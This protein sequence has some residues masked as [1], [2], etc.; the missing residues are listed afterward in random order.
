MKYRPEID[1]LRAFAVVPV[2]LFHAGFNLFSGGFVGVDIFF[3]ISGYL[4]TTIIIEDLE[5]NTF[6][7][8]HFYERRTRRILPALFFVIFACIPFAW[9]WM[10]PVQMEDFSKSIIFVI[11][12]SSNILFAQEID[13]FDRDAEENPLLHTWSLAVEEQYYFIFPIALLLCWRFGKSKVFW[14]I[15][16]LAGVSLALSEAGWR[17]NANANFYFTPSRAWELF[18]GSVAA[19]I[20]QKRGIKSN[21]VFSLAG[22]IAILYAIFFYDKTTPF[23]SAY[24]LIPVIGIFLILLYAGSET[25]TAKFLSA[26]L[27][28]S[29]GLVSYSAYLWHQPL[30]AFAKIRLEQEPDFTTIVFIL[31]ATA[32]LSLLTWR[33]IERPFRD[34]EKISKKGLLTVLSVSVLLLLSFA[35]MGDKTKG[36]RKETNS[37]I[38]PPPLQTGHVINQPLFVFGDS[39]AEHLIPGLEKFNNGKTIDMTSPGCIPFRNVDR[40]DDRFEPGECARIMNANIDVLNRVDQPSILVISSMGPVYLDGSVFKGK[41]TARVEGLG[42]ELIT[43]PKV[44]DHYKIFETGMRQTLSEL[45]KNDHLKV[46]FTIDIPELGIESGCNY[47][48]KEI[49]VFGH[50]LKDLLSNPPKSECTV[51]LKEYNERSGKYKNLIYRTAEDFPSVY[52]FDPTKYFCGAESCSGYVDEFGYLYHDF[53]HLSKNGSYYY[54]SKLMDEVFAKSDN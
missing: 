23:P 6:S 1:G 37:E 25:F 8:A 26:K 13:Y 4:I 46:I 36:F 45:S 35:I 28:I 27:F 24:A 10:L 2:I 53:D 15:V 33:Y 41:D 3:V 39:H 16:V 18:A 43:D 47:P 51:S 48:K 31:V 11:F 12:F 19:F 40:Y 17:Y 50:K 54:A 34:R 7:L 22:L 30:L 32:L 44:A 42:V 5:Q 20:V 52:L 29:V 14:A 21:D 9:I 38:L 49:S